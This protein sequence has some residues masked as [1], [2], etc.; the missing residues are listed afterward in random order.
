MA[1]KS[2]LIA[3]KIAA[4][5]VGSYNRSFVSSGCDM[6]N[7]FVFR[8]DSQNTGDTG[9][10]E[11]WWTTAPS[12]SASTLNYV[13]MC[14]TPVVPV[15]TDGDAKYRGLNQDP[16]KFSVSASSVGDA[17]LPRHGDIVTLSADAFTAAKS[18][19][20]YA[21]TSDG[22][23]QLVW[24]SSQTSNALSFKYLATTY[25]SVAGSGIGDQRLVAYKLACVGN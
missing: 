3:N 24:G 20:T 2:V 21:N 9:Y 6:Q 13:W 10:S 1:N 8:L 7:G 19:S 16:R 23:Y 25:V 4:D 11:V 15:T 14:N 17:F 18:S 22:S 5:D 12:L